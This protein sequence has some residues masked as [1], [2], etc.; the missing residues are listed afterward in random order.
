MQ[1][2]EDELTEDELEQYHAGLLTWDKAKNW[3][4]WIRKEWTLYYILFVLIIVVVA[5]MAFFHRSVGLFLLWLCRSGRRRTTRFGISKLGTCR[6][7]GGGCGATE[8]GSG[9][10]KGSGAD[11]LG[12]KSE[13]RSREE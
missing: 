11:V 4:F 2:T 6:H 12:G 8:I 10:R 3:R 5:L 7:A 1:E 13:E 9:R